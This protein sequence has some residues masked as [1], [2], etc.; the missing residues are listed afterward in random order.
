MDSKNKTRN[1]ESI[2]RS[3]VLGTESLM[4][5]SRQELLELARN[6]SNGKYKKDSLQREK[7]LQ[8]LVNQLSS[9]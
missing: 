6:L 7:I 9:V 1:K 2:E 4:N 8:L 3:T 5:H